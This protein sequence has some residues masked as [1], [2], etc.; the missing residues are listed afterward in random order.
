MAATTVTQPGNDIT[1]VTLVSLLGVA[2]FT[3]MA[4]FSDDMGKLMVVVMWG[5]VLIWAI[6]HTTELANMVKVL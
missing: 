5:I 2:L 6:T 4:G 3:I 1:A